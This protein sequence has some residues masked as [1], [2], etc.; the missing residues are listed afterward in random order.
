MRAMTRSLALLVLLAVT[1]GFAVG[2]P[3]LASADALKHAEKHK[4][5]KYKITES[6]ESTDGSTIVGNV[7]T[8]YADLNAPRFRSVLFNHGIFSGAADFESVYV[9]NNATDRTIHLITETLTEKGKTDPKTIEMLKQWERAIGFPRKEASVGKGSGD[10]TPATRNPSKSILEN[11]VDLENHKNVIK[12]KTQLDGKAVVKYH[13]EEERQTTTLF[14]EP[15]TNLPIRVE[16]ETSKGAKPPI[17]LVKYV[18]SD[19]QWDPS[20]KGFRSLDQLFSTT[21]PRGYNV[22]QFATGR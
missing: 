22:K 3:D 4:L 10:F 2:L 19:F 20:L 16:Y 9:R 12:S 14:V 21:P 5:V 6:P 15:D 13:L 11:F 1:G 8:A 7:Y 18:L 17:R